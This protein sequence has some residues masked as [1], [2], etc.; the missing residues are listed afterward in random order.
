[1]SAFEG[2]DFGTMVLTGAGVVAKANVNELRVG[3]LV[4]R[5]LLDFLLA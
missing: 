3:A 1:M 4:G 5:S 2:A